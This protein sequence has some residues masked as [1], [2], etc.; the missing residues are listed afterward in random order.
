[1]R[2]LPKGRPNLPE[3][4][5]AYGRLNRLIKNEPLRA[6][7]MSCPRSRWCAWVTGR[8]Y[9]RKETAPI[10]AMEYALILDDFAKGMANVR[11]PD[12]QLPAMPQQP[13]SQ[14]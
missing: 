13:G 4:Q 7:G 1:M 14:P 3:R 8:N 12:S 9:E 11:A 2:V 10:R 6:V 5:G